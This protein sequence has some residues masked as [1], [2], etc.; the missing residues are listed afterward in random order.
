MPVLYTPLSTPLHCPHFSTSACCLAFST[1]VHRLPLSAPVFSPLFH[2][3]SLPITS[4]SRR[5]DL[6][7]QEL[8]PCLLLI[9]PIISPS[10]HVATPFQH[11]YLCS[12]PPLIPSSSHLSLIVPIMSQSPH[13][14]T[15]FQQ[16]YLCTSPPLLPSSSHLHSSDCLLTPARILD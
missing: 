4:S 9:L 10:P 12:S 5:N 6:T 1:P 3:L 11:L 14:A 16:S 13:V 15:P 2:L 7:S 8:L